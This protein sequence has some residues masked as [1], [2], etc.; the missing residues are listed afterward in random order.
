MIRWIPALVGMTV[1]ARRQVLRKL[2]GLVHPEA[3]GES[4]IILTGLLLLARRQGGC[5]IIVAP[6][7]LI[8]FRE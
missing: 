8:S 2:L 7:D 5:G 1:M 4:M 6:D 3:Y